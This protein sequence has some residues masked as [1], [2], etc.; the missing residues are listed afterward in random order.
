[1]HLFRQLGNEMQEDI[2]IAQLKVLADAE[3]KAFQQAWHEEARAEAK[4]R[5][6]KLPE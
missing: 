2:A 6:W 1:M 5:G 3:Q 4:E